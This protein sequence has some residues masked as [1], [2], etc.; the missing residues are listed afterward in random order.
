MSLMRPIGESAAR[1]ASSALL[2]RSPSVDAGDPTRAWTRCGAPS[3]SFAPAPLLDLP[4]DLPL[5]RGI[6]QKMRERLI[7]VCCT[8]V[9]TSIT[10]RQFGIGPRRSHEGKSWVKPCEGCHRLESGSNRGAL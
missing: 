4:L 9:S 2:P 8:D 1:Y 3:S 6:V 7:R 10:P 5:D